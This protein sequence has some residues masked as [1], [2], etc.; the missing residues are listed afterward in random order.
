MHSPPDAM[1]EEDIYFSEEAPQW[2]G[3]CT[4]QA[5]ATACE[6]ATSKFDG[7]LLVPLHVF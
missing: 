7:P 2:F 3:K 4:S 6:Q 5:F 1:D